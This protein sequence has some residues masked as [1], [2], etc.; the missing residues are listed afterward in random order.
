MDLHQTAWPE[1]SLSF[2]TLKNESPALFTPPPTWLQKVRAP[3]LK[4]PALHV[5]QHGFAVG[6][7][8]GQVWRAKKGVSQAPICC[9]GRGRRG[10]KFNPDLRLQTEMSTG[11]RQINVKMGVHEGHKTTASQ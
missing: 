10:T 7:S 5:A 4:P 9:Q 3:T 2:L 8:G 1:T 6:G 11:C